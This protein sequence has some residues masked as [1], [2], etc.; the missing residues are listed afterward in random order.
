MAATQDE[1]LDVAIEAARAGAAELSARFGRS[2]RDVRTK[3]NATD[4][5]SEADLASE[6]AIREVLRSR[7]PDDTVIG[8]EGGAVHGSGELSWIVDPL[9]GTV[10]FLYGIPM[11]AV[12]VAC[13]D[14]SGALA[15][16]VIDPVRDECFAATRSAS[17]A[18]L[19]GAAISGPERDELATA[20]VATGFGYDPEIRRIQASAAARL[21]PV[22]RDIRRAGA[23]ALDLAWTACGRF[24]AFYER[25]LNRWDIAAGALICERAGVSV[26]QLP[27]LLHAP[28]GI[29]AAP[30]AIV[31]ELMALVIQD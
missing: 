5:V 15:G 8:E 11:F 28:E 21:I 12:S 14:A 30:P 22:V 7:R 25:G 16:I 20:L 27:G 18:T 3:S 29:L 13:E 24:D 26:R 17:G 31:D 23:A 9:D 4:P 2:P 10:N 19:N 6:S 1:L